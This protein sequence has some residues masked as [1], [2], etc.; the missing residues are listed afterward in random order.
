M[1]VDM[2]ETIVQ[3]SL[4]NLHDIIV[5]E[6]VGFF[7][8]AP[9]WI[10]V[11]LST[12]SLFFHFSWKAYKR[13]KRALYKKE[14]LKELERY[15]LE[16]KDEL[17]ALLSLAK[18]VAISAYGRTQ[19]AKLSGENWWDFMEQHSQVKVS[20][21]LRVE[22]SDLLYDTS[23]QYDSTQHATIKGLVRLWIR[24]HKVSRDV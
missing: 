15:T 9:G 8:L 22:L 3:A 24:T 2:N 7:P 10:I 4:D 6:A 21:E 16:S 12:F 5:P 18:R 11:I 1:P 17:V 20:K 14:A 19:I 13:Y 23:K